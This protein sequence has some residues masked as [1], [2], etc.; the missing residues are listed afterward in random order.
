MNTQQQ[1]FELAMQVRDYECD[2][3]RIVNN[4]NY[5][6]YLE[7]A[8]HKFL[9]SIHINFAELTKQ[10]INMVVTSVD[11]NYLAPL[12]A[13]DEFVIS[14]HMQRVSRLRF[15]FDQKILRMPDRKLMLKAT[16]VGTVIDGNEK[17]CM[18]E[19]LEKLLG[20]IVQS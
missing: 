5:M 13:G 1:I 6:N 19:S 4:A 18:P 10:Q 3:Q 12:V 16:T 17:P 20:P 15:S 8:R 2:M 11:L 14:V 7:H 9:E